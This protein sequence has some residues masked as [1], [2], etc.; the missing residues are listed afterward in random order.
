MPSNPEYSV[1]I[2][3][4]NASSTLKDLFLRLYATM[5]NLEKPFELIF[6]DDCSKDNSWQILLALKKEHTF[7]KIYQLKTNCGQHS[8]TLCGVTKSHGDII[9]TIDDDLQIAPEEIVKMVEKQKLTGAGLV[10]GYFENKKQLAYKNMGRKLLFTVFKKTLTKYKYVSSFRLF[11]K[12]LVQDL[13][14]SYRRYYTFDVG[15]IAQKPIVDFVEVEHHNRKLGQSGYSF[16]YLVSFVVSFFINYTQ[17]P[18]KILLY[19][20]LIMAV[21]GFGLSAYFI[22]NSPDYFL[23]S[24]I[25]CCTGLIMIALSLWSE[26][27]AR[28]VEAN[29]AR[30]LFVINQRAE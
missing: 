10:Y 6:V 18:I 15:L 16:G 2:P 4:Y 11:H 22:V 3:V 29:S 13:N 8:A 17:L 25:W 9:I 19:F 1:I 12:Q 5:K 23:P 21:S 14:T 24:I 26:Y 20:G 7:V 27:F 28:Y 30:Q